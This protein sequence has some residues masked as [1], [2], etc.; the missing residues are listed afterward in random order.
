[1]SSSNRIGREEAAS[2]AVQIGH[3]I[4]TVLLS[5]DVFLGGVRGTTFLHK[6]GFLEKSSSRSGDVATATQFNLTGV[7]EVLSAELASTC[8][9]IQQVNLVLGID[10]AIDFPSGRVLATN[11]DIAVPQHC[12]SAPNP[13]AVRE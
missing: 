3:G 11:A 2:N 9:G 6:K 5:L 8:G 13:F 4:L 12:H 7:L 10:V 1:M